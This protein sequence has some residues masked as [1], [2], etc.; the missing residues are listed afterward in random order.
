MR[1]WHLT[2][3]AF[4]LVLVGAFLPWGQVYLR[5]AAKEAEG[6]DAVL[7]GFASTFTRVVEATAWNS[8]VTIGTGKI[9]SWVAL[10]LCALAALLAT[11]RAGGMRALPAAASPILG[12]A[13]AAIPITFAVMYAAATESATLRLGFW[14]FATG[15]IGVVLTTLHD[16]LEARPRDSLDR[17]EP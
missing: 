6:I 1:S 9:P 10:V 5:E 14:L 17:S 7:V 2:W 12:A 8:H 4:A 15:A 11:L 13:G 3:C 16:P